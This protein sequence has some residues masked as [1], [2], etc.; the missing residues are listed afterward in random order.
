MMREGFTCPV[1]GYVKFGENPA[2]C[3][4]INPKTREFR[5]VEKFVEAYKEELSERV[6]EKMNEAFKAVPKV[7]FTEQ[8]VKLVQEQL[9]EFLR[10]SLP[11]YSVKVVVK[12]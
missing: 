12:E 3:G 2:R 5:E 1:H 7:P 9:D 6:A 4:C 11:H 8:G 10:E